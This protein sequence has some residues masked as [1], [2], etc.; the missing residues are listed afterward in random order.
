[1]RATAVTAL[2]H[3]DVDGRAR[4]VDVS[5]KQPTVR[6][7]KVEGSIQLSDEAFDALQQHALAKGDPYTVAKLAGL[8]AAK[9]T[10]EL[11][12]LCHPLP[13]DHVDVRFETD[14]NAQLIRVIALVSATAKT[15]V[16]MEALTAA[17]AALLAL[18]DMVKAVDPSA[19]ITQLRLLEK[20]GGKQG[21]RRRPDMPDTE[22][23]CAPRW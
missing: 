18:Y 11:I 13:L 23:A 6:Q 15:G 10:A 20:T 22:D 1:M 5:G 9:R 3:V 21:Y 4:M 2:S 19:M 8:Q 7:A 16:E 14:A 12:P 17:A